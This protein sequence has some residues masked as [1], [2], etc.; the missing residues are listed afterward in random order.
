MD[1]SQTWHGDDFHLHWKIVEGEDF[2]PKREEE[3]ALLSRI[4][5]KGEQSLRSRFAMKYARK[6][7]FESKQSSQDLQ[8]EDNASPVHG[9][10]QN[11]LG[12]LFGKTDD[13]SSNLLIKNSSD[14][15]EDPHDVVSF[16]VLPSCFHSLSTVL[17]D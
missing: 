6:V 16:I 2:L 8:Q 5:R 9:R 1:E 14:D 12:R 7:L 15:F 13:K 10:K 17:H 3:S 11:M 4:D